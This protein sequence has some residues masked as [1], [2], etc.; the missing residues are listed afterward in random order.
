MKHATK[1]LIY[2]A[3]GSALV[4]YRSETHP[5]Y[6]FEADLPG[7]EIEKGEDEL[8]AVQ[9]EV[10]EEA[11]ITIDIDRLTLANKRRT[12]YGRIDHIFTTT[13]DEVQ[14]KVILSWEHHDY[15]WVEKESL[16]E[17]LDTK[18]DYMIVVREYLEKELAISQS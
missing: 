8:L 6:A 14:P 4:L 15:K 10:L 5:H 1:I 7:G 13:I 12:L 2:D 16:L 18:D 9:R 3:A 17:A 11:G